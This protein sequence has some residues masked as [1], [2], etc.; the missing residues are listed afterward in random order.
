MIMMGLRFSGKEP[1]AEVFLHGLVR[2]EFGQKMSKTKGNVIDPLEVVEEFGADAVRFT[3]AIV[4]SGRDIPLARNRMQGYAAF[5]TKIWNAARFALTYIDTP[6]RQAARL[7]SR[8]LTAVDRWILSRLNSTTRT[9]D[10][11]LRTYRFD[12]A[13]NALYQFFWNEFCAWYIEMAKPVLSG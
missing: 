12:E 10:K 6:L 13:A 11:S 9:V 8:S 2:D 5:A 3:L 4:C 7:D 1:I